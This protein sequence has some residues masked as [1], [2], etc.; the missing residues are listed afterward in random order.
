M[1]FLPHTDD[2]RKAMLATI[3]VDGMRDLF[4]DIPAEFHREPGSLNLPEALSEAGI[5]RKFTERV[6]CKRCLNSRP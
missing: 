1:R 2:D 3:G 4:A 5:V 6:H